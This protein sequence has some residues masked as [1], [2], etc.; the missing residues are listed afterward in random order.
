MSSRAGAKERP[1]GAGIMDN[2][3]FPFLTYYSGNGGAKF[4]KKIWLLPEIERIG[5][6]VRVRALPN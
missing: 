4:S 6:G 1:L 5:G 2:L 3:S